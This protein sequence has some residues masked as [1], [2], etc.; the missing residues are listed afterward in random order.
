MKRKKSPDEM[1]VNAS[2]FLLLG[3]MEGFEVKHV[4]EYHLTGIWLDM[5]VQ[6]ERRPASSTDARGENR[7][8]AR[9]EARPKPE[10]IKPKEAHRLEGLVST[11]TFRRALLLVLLTTAGNLPC[12]SG[13]VSAHFRGE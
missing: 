4:D 3:Q 2:V 1:C 7:A 10:Q 6:W 13:Q 12:F 11:S 8:E 9:G 5:F